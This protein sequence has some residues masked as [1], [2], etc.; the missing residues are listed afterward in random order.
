MALPIARIVAGVAL[1]AVLI[2]VFKN[3]ISGQKNLVDKAKSIVE[4]TA[5]AAVDAAESAVDKATDVVKDTKRSV[6]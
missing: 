2:Y 3:K 6:T 5:D 1:A 4:D